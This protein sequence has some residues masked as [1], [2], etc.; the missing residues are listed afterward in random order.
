MSSF[1]QVWPSFLLSGW[2]VC[3][4]RRVLVL[5]PGESRWV[6]ATSSIKVIK[7]RDRQTDRQR[8]DVRPLNYAFTTRRSQCNNVRH[9]FVR[10]YA[11]HRRTSSSPDEQCSDSSA[12]CLP[13]ADT[14]RLFSD[15]R[16]ALP[17][18]HTVT[19]GHLRRP[20]APM[21]R[22]RLG[23]TVVDRRL[24]VDDPCSGVVV[25]T[26]QQTSPWWGRGRRGVVRVPR[27]VV[28]VRR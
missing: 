23:A 27:F 13:C 15:V 11:F 1:E 8:G 2:N 18:R 17:R 24:F 4:S 12:S 16:P 3:W 26:N 28:I 7:R 20:A 10:V 5:L 22:L 6:C 21:S 25:R 19:G 14:A 9:R